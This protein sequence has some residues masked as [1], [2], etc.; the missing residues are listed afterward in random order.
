[1]SSNGLN[2]WKNFDNDH[3]QWTN[4]KANKSRYR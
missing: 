3:E 4:Q 1:M 2:P